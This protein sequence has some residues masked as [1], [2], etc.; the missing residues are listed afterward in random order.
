MSL[1]QPKEFDEYYITCPSCGA[2]MFISVPV[3]TPFQETERNT[4]LKDLTKTF[5]KHLVGDHKELLS[6]H[7]HDIGFVH[8]TLSNQNMLSAQ[9][10]QALH[11]L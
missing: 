5:M 9:W 8:P 1:L 10:L 11:Y 2:R 6:L 7:K 4:C 3:D